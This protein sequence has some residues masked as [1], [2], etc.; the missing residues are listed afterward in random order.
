MIPM[1]N[2][3]G[4]LAPPGRGHLYP[5]TALGRRL[6]KHGYQVTVFDRCT[7]KA[8]VAASG[9]QFQAIDITDKHDRAW[10]AGSEKLVGPQSLNVLRAHASLVLRNAYNALADAKIEALLVDQA[11]LAGGTLADRLGIPFIN[12]SMF[13]PVFLSE[14]VPPFIFPWTYREDSRARLRNKRGNALFSRLFDPILSDVNQARVQWKLPELA[15]L[16]DLF[17]KKAIVSQ[18]PRILDFPRKL[19]PPPVCYTGPFNDGL[20]R[21][22]VTFPWSSLNG[23][24]IVY[25]SMGTV[26]CASKQV[27][28]TIAAACARFNLQLVM[29]LGGMDLTPSN[30]ESAPADAIIVHF[31][32]Q[33]E[34]L[35]KAALCITHGGMNTVL[36][37]VASGVPLVV[38]PVTDDQPGVAARIEWIGAGLSLPLRRLS[39]DRLTERI[40]TVLSNPRFL[41]VAKNLETELKQIDG[42]ELAAEIIQS[43]LALS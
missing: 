9:L 39:L 2:R 32:P 10:A 1:I 4:I 13:P 36:D 43:K 6:K 23:K 34:L 42:L 24:P 41:H 33:T 38:L 11:D 28:E 22:A 8:V 17:S 30:I 31:A 26:R 40:E 5:A 14:D 16:N 35:R 25:A 15:S 29:T 21:P 20:G 12:L 19:D 18:L 37:A 27:F 7:A 3:L